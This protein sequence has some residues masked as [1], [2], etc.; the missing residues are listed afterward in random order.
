MNFREITEDDFVELASWFS[1]I[2]KPYP[3]KEGVIPKVGIAYVDEHGLVACCFLKQDSSN[4]ARLEWIASNPNRA[5][6]YRS[7]CTKKL[8]DFMVRSIKAATP[9]VQII[10]LFTQSDFIINSCVSL[11]FQPIRGFTRL[12][13]TYGNQETT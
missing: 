2:P 7:E 6:S 1:G 12:L 5:N 13:Y 9:Q 10:E 11:K 3:L 8:I 4:I